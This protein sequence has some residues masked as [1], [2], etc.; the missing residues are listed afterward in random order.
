M[1]TPPVDLSHGRS[2]T[3]SF[4]INTWR[5][6]LIEYKSES[7]HRSNCRGMYT[8]HRLVSSAQ[9]PMIWQPTESKGQQQRP[10]ISIAMIS[11][12]RAHQHGA[13]S[14]LMETNSQEHLTFFASRST[15]QPRHMCVHARLI[16]QYKSTG[17]AVAPHTVRH[18]HRCFA[19]S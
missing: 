7:M 15:W 8:E 12:K 10:V 4:S 9:P 2:I 14:A 13:V 3:D 6:S 18:G 16:D 11:Q 5:L 19:S 1:M 17:I